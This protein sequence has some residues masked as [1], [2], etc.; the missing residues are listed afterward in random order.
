MPWQI[1][2][3]Q[4]PMVLLIEEDEGCAERTPPWGAPDIGAY[5]ERLRG[6]LRALRAYPRLKLG[7]EWSG[8]ELERLAQAAPD[9]LADLR[10]LAAEARRR[11][12]RCAVAVRAPS[13]VQAG[14]CRSLPRELE[15][16]IRRRSA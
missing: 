13:G 5:L 15:F 8:L 2:V 1:A 10:T 11:A 4:H 16:E 3:A 12:C 6:N 14:G 9:V 7:F